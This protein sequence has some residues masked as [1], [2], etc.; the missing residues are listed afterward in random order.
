MAVISARMESRYQVSG[1]R[2]QVPGGYYEASGL[3]I[4]DT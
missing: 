3:P 4:P 2:D 1:F